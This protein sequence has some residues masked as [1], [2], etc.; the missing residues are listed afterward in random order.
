MA[1]S[2][3]AILTSRPPA[4]DH[5]TYL[6]ILELHLRPE[7]LPTL[8]EVLHDHALTEN[9]GWDLVGLLVPL[10][11]E[12]KACLWEVARWGNPREVILKVLEALREIDFEDQD[13]GSG[14]KGLLDT[15]PIS[16]GPEEN[17]SKDKPASAEVVPEQ[18]KE[19]GQISAAVSRA[20]L[21]FKALLPVLG[22]LH[23][24]IKTQS[25]SRFVSSTLQAVLACYADAA[26]LLPWRLLDDITQ[27]IIQ[28]A[29]TLS[30]KK[31]PPLPPR[32][33]THDVL[34]KQDSARDT[35]LKVEHGNDGESSAK[36]PSPEDQAIQERLLQSFVT[37]LLEEYLISTPRDDE[38]PGLA[39]T[40]R[41]QEKAHPD[42][43][44]PVR[45]SF[46]ELFTE[47][48]QLQSRE[49][50]VGDLVV[51]CSNFDRCVR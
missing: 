22:I 4:T 34:V 33:S 40:A 41:F 32:Q 31:R 48:A 51:S 20:V 44:I 38:V 19:D 36:A 25:P 49:R 42:K 46:G 43:I 10:L 37:H 14:E 1:E 27:S 7:L 24:R 21:Q 28:L 12:S 2:I 9:I 35:E 39:W 15:T 30:G 26:P 29:Q 50:T 3:D 45:P 5:T 17:I 23:S 47:R 11:P 13:A 16:P 8:Q 6:T 18:A